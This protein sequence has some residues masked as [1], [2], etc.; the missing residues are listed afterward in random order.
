MGKIWE[1]PF[2]ALGKGL[3]SFCFFEKQT[4]KHTKGRRNKDFTQRYAINSLKSHS[5]EDEFNCK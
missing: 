1:R 4:H 2:L 3:T 5:S